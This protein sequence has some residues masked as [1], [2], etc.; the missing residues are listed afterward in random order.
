[1]EATLKPITVRRYGDAG[2]CVHVL[3]GGPG[4]PGSAPTLAE[5][6]AGGFRVH[7]PLQ[8][9]SG[10][11]PLTVAKHVADLDAA[12]EE[13][14]LLVGWSWG[15][16][17]AL[18]YSTAHQEKVRGVALVGCGTYDTASRA[19]YHQAMQERLTAHDREELDA[20]RK[21][22]ADIEDTEERDRLFGRIGAIDG[23]AQSVDLLR[24]AESDVR[25]DAGGYE[26]W[27]DVLRL[28]AEDVEPQAFTA[29]TAPVVLIQGERDPHP[30]ALIYESLHRYIPQLA[31]V[32]VPES[33]HAPWLERAGRE[34]FL[35][36]LTAWLTGVGEA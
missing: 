21:A 26:T 4:A 12:I 3:H 5:A 28:Q 33:G 22:M 2:P 8:R 11:V 10:E 19:A 1:M 6:L 27:A 17:L 31:F 29:I 35:A 23:R 20:L 7:E 30:G 18:S 14:T 32:E 15:A 36:E 34:R 24:E 25:A 13:D 9:R 16:M